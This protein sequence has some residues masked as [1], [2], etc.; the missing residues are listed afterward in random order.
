MRAVLLTPQGQVLLMKVQEPVSR[1]HFWIAPGGG[2]DRGESVEAGLC[3]ELVEETGL[4]GVEVGPLLWTRTHEFV[5]DGE[6]IFQ[7]EEFYLVETALFEPTM[8]HNPEVGERSAFQAFRWWSVAE[9]RK[10]SELFVPRRLPELLEALIRLGPPAEVF[11]VG[12]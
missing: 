2:I 3:R 8:E 7:R 4:S 6:A 12:L 1:R 5:W 11:D 9:M 10:A